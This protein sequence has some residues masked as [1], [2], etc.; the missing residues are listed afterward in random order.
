MKKT[1]SIILTAV[2]VLGLLSV[3][4]MTGSAEAAPEGTAITNAAEFAAMT[5]DGKYY[6]ANDITVDATWNAGNPVSSTYADNAAFTGVLDGNG[7]TITQSAPLFANLQG[8]VKNL[9]TAGKLAASELHAGNITMWTKGT[10]VIDNVTTGA[11]VPSGK[12]SGGIIGYAATGSN[13]T[14]TNSVNNANVT[15]SD[16]AGGIIGYCQD[17]VLVIDNCENNGIIT[18]AN[19]GAGIAGRFGRDA[20]TASD[21]KCAITNCV[22]NGKVVGAKGQS[23]G[24]VGY[25]VGALVIDSCVNNGEIINET[26]IAGGIYGSSKNTEKAVDIKIKNCVNN[27]SVTGKTRVGGIAGTL[28]VGVAYESFRI[29]NCINNGKVTNAASDGFSSNFQTGGIVGYSYGGNIVETPNGIINCVNAGELVID[30]TLAAEGA[31]AQVGGIT[32]YVN[33]QVWEGKNNANLGKITISGNMDLTV[34]TIYNKN[35]A[36]ANIVGNFSVAQ[37]GVEIALAGDPP[38]AATFA[39]AATAADAI[40]ALNTAA[41]S[42]LYTLNA[43]GTVAKNETTPP[44]HEHTLEDI[45]AKAPT[46]TEKGANAGKKCSSCDYIEGCEEIAALGHKF[47]DGK[48]SVCQADDPDYVAPT[49]TTQGTTAGEDPEVTTTEAPQEDKGCGGIS[50]FAVLIAIVSGAAVVIFKKKA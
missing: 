33:S 22:N 26:A 24:M 20:A 28:G 10:V 49:T 48:C 38:A 25:L 15:C 43:D 17:D 34:L 19:Y 8:T 6:L 23:G 16:Q 1:L 27:G 40:A 4:P 2:M 45:P 46:C 7:K 14:I 11:E 9:K 32:A 42:E 41:G 21:S 36:D 30:A 29:E 44:T 47:A 35:A 3:V 39:T 31:T 13:V 12:T 50:V 37:D 18:T 5:A